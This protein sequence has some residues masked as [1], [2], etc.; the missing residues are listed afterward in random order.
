MSVW[1]F[2]QVRN[3]KAFLK[4]FHFP[5]KSSTCIST[6]ERI[7]TCSL[8]AMHR[9]C[10][11]LTPLYSSTT[12]IEDK[13]WPLNHLRIEIMGIK[14]D[15]KPLVTRTFLPTFFRSNKFIVVNWFLKSTT[16]QRFVTLYH[17][18]CKNWWVQLLLGRFEKIQLIWEGISAFCRLT[19]SR[20]TG[21]M[22]RA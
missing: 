15:T 16:S 13:G 7:G 12:H 21:I 4:F 10:R 18:R 6:R 17:N 8:E 5:V 14:H 20:T 1:F 2:C 19:R 22:W 3:I 11:H 9:L